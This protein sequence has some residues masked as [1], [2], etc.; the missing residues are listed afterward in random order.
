MCSFNFVT[1]VTEQSL[2]CEA[3]DGSRGRKQFLN[4]SKFSP[5]HHIGF[6]FNPINEIELAPG[7]LLIPRS[8]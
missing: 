7:W 8:G 6:V 3:I 4:F 2:K 5:F 1:V